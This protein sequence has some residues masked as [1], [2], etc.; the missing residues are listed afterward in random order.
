MRKHSP[1]SMV[2]WYD[3]VTMQGKLQ[4]QDRLT[5]LNQPFF[6]ACDG[7]FVNYTWQVC[8]LA[9]KCRV[10]TSSVRTRRHLVWLPAGMQTLASVADNMSA[11]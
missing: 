3:A 9:C 7:L 11:V 6:D 8:G 5:D 2:L 4:W 1:H 10:K